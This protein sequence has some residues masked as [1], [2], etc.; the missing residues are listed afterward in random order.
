MHRFALRACLAS[1]LLP[2]ALV[3]QEPSGLPGQPRAPTAEQRAAVATEAV[4]RR[5]YDAFCAGDVATLERLYAP[6]VRFRDEIFSFDDRAG[7]MGMWRQLLAPAAGKRFTYELLSA[8]AG[9][10]TVR[11]V[12]DYRFP[13]GGRPVHN[14]ITARLVIADGLVV[15]H[16][17]SFSWEA[18]SRQAFPLGRLATWGPVERLLKAGLRFGLAHQARQAA[19]EAPAASAAGPA[20]SPG[21]TGELDPAAAGR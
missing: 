18:W 16:Q 3:A 17:D 4:A 9:D 11:W 12:A 5:F 7:T 10:A 15:E 14:V 1:L 21:F 19:R 8:D 2:A 20:E 13:L 6:T